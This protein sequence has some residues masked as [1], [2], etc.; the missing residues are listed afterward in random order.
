MYSFRNEDIP[1]NRE[2]RS[3]L[4]IVWGLGSHKSSLVVAKIGL[5]YPF[6]INNLNPYYFSLLSFLLYGLVLSSVRLKRVISMNIKK[7]I[8]SGAYRGHRHALF[9]PVRG[10]RTRTNASTGKRNK[11]KFSK[12]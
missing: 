11:V 8:D 12:K 1:E 6:F 2:L 10:Q 4:S 5:S 3:A 7:L 9:L